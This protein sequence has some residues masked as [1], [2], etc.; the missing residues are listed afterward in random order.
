[1][2]SSPIEN[3]PAS[4]GYRM[5]AEWERHEATWLTWPK[6]D[7]ISFPGNYV[8]VLPVFA[9][10]VREL[11]ESEE[12]RIIV[13]DA[14][15]ERQALEVIGKKGASHVRFFHIPSNEP[16][17]RDHGP[18]FLKRDGDRALALVD[19][20]F[21]AWGFKY[22]PFD[23]D[24]TIPERIAGVLGIPY[25]TPD[26]VL[27]GGSIDVNGEGALLTTESCLL[28]PN[29]NPEMTR[30]Q[31]EG[32]LCA[33]LGVSEVLWLGDGISGDDTDGH[34]DDLSRFVSADTVVTSIEENDDDENYAALRDNLARLQEMRAG[35][36]DLKV[37]M[38]PMPSKILREGLR[39]PASY[40]NFY[41]ANTV[42]LMPSYADP[43]DKWAATILQNAFPD[44]RIVPI[45][46]CE[47]VWG[48]GAFHCLTQQ[49]P[50]P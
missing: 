24:D 47:L 41:I 28:N 50:A 19:W 7:G 16:W 10:M 31:I 49:Q 1:M 3:T 33:Y 34:V 22:P 4:Q 11:G 18:T 45:D 32:M 38:L 37:V 15:G 29:R 21:N 35:G 5:P 39:L 13:D 43:N 6:P 12:V 14:E 42:V 25:Y 36:E 46:C 20:G 40:A 44:R 48:L 27:E 2:G 23:L 26:M 30:G 8:K 17:C 9:R